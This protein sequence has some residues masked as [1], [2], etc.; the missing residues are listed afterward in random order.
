MEEVNREVTLSKSDALII[1]AYHLPLTVTRRETGGFDVAWDDERGLNRDG[2][3]LPMAPTYVGCIDVDVPEMFEQEQ[4]E[5]LLLEQFGCVVVFLEP[6]LK[7]RYYHG[8]CRGYLAPIMHNQYHVMQDVDPF[9]PDEWRAYCAVNQLF[10][11][12]VMGVSDH[13]GAAPMVWIHDYHLLLLPSCLVRKLGPVA[14]IGFFL[15]APF[16]SSDV[17]RTVACRLELLRSLLNADLLGFLMFEYTR[18]FLTC[19][20]RMLGLEYEFQKGGF[21][22]VEYEGRHVILQVGFPR[23]SRLCS[24]E[25]AAATCALGSGCRMRARGRL[26]HAREGAAA[27]CARGGGCRMRAR[28]RRSRT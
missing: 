8:F 9:Q 27:A 14:K 20:K 3:G 10:A 28:G 23:T 11:A 18:N 21:L 5:K 26:P 2:L 1:A 15:H 4:L 16:P 7:A 24:S 17:W 19:C 12:K 22:G 25:G 6:E 13:D